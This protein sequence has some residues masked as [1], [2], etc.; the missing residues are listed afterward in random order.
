MQLRGHVRRFIWTAVDRD[1][2]GMR[3]R[4][5]PPAAPRGF[6]LLEMVVTL[7][8]AG[9]L[10]TIAIGSMQGIVKENTQSTAVNQLVTQLVQARSEATKR[11]AQVVLC[12]SIDK[13]NCVAK[14]A[15]SSFNWWQTGMI[16]FADN[17]NDEV[18]DASE[19]IIQRHA[20]PGGLTVK[21]STG[22]GR[23]A[24]TPDGLSQ[25]SNS[26]FTFCDSRGTSKARYVI[27]SNTGRPRV[28]RQPQ[29]GTA[30]APDEICT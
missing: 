4:H 26:T 15:G 14:A 17:N 12:P 10:T 22:S 20:F 3:P 13:S 30:D 7:A 5:L 28:S 24:F 19:A 9:I 2:G 16:A 21:T 25:L 18:R 27:L 11:R 23:I 1:T 6:T 29:D 8:I